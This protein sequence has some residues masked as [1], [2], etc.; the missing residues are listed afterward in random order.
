MLDK[1]GPQDSRIANQV[2]VIAFTADPTVMSIPLPPFQ[3]LSS[4]MSSGKSTFLSKVAI[5]LRLP[6][7]ARKQ[8]VP[9]RSSG[10]NDNRF[11]FC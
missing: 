5:V 2:L 7:H 4:G 11:W 9:H 10:R 8:Q 6:L 3:S 1:V